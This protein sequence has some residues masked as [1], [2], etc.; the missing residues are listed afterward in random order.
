M[1][2]NFTNHKAMLTIEEILQL[3]TSDKK[4][5]A[6]K[7]RDTKAPDVKNLKKQWN[8]ETHSVM[9]DALRPNK[10]IF[11]EDGTTFDRMEPV[12]RIPI[13]L[14]KLIVNRAVSF[15]FGNPVELIYN[16]QDANTKTVQESIKKVLSKNKEVSLNK[17]MGKELL[18]STEVAE[19]WYTVDTKVDQDLYGFKSPM[20]LRHKIF[21]PMN[22]DNLYP[23]FDDTG[24]LIAFSREFIILEQEVEILH[25][26]T[27]TA[28]N[29]YTFKQKDGKYEDPI[30]EKNPIGKIPVIYGTQL[31]SEWNDVQNLIERLEVL[32]SNFADTNDYHGSP[33]IMIEGDIQGFAK[34]GEQ[35]KIL[36]GSAGTKAYYLSWDR[37]PEAIKLEKDM[38]IEMI[39]T[40]TQTPNITFDSLK[41]LGQIA[42]MTLKLLFLDAHLKVED[43]KGIV[44]EYLQRRINIIKA[45]LGIMNTS[46]KST[47]EAVDITVDVKPYMLED[48]KAYLDYIMAAN[49]GSQVISQRTSIEKSGLTQDA[50]AEYAQI[51]SE[52]SARNMSSISNPS[53]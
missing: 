46:W 52:E 31:T 7:V 5:A 2:R 19:V 3:E 15:L 14:Q 36:Q 50:E 20:K 16:N 34:K 24:D 29:T 27:Y 32:A 26:E 12:N 21:S 53:M 40:L 9:D 8:V 11:K 42:T 10:K 6:L 23:L 17:A 33:T 51:Q 39:Y 47:I 28:L 1:P 22:G 48:E 45:F 44:L 4:V 35:G 49:G 25:F 37:A 13:S 30:I 38:L 43:K 18:S 41:G